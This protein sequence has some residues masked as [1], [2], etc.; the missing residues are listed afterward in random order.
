MAVPPPAPNAGAGLPA[1]LGQAGAA[2]NAACKAAVLA[3]R[4][5]ANA[6]KA[7]V[8]APIFVNEADAAAMH[9]PCRIDNMEV[10][11]GINCTI[12]QLTAMIGEV[13]RARG[14][15]AVAAG[16][17]GGA[18]A[19][20][21]KLELLFKQPKLAIEVGDQLLITHCERMICMIEEKEA[22]EMGG[23]S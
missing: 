5:V 12:L 2:N 6:A 21:R 11:D 15:A 3:Q 22:R 16:V 9:C 14:A 23:G 10:I 8:R 19:A 13:I 1:A 18:V 17:T 7:R 4:F 20:H